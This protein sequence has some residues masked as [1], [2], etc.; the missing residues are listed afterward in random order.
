MP[1]AIEHAGD[2]CLQPDSARARPGPC[3][4]QQNR[5]DAALDETPRGELAPK[6][7][8]IRN[9]LG[10]ALARLG[11]M[12]E[13]IDQFRE[14]MRLNPSSALAHANLGLA[15][16]G[17]GKA[18]ESILEFEAALRLNPELNTAAAGLRQAQAQLSPQ[19]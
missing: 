14:A 18:Q 5:N 6:D 15:L 9:N 19:R 13:A 17:S 4:W 1:E 8:D 10:L 16:L 12:P 2:N 7:A 11:R 3:R